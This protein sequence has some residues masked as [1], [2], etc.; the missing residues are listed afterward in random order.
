MVPFLG[1]LWIISIFG[2]G[3]WSLS[4]GRYHRRGYAVQNPDTPYVVLL[5]LA[6]LCGFGGGNFAS[7]MAT[8]PSSFQEGEGQR[9]R[10]QCGTRQSWVS[11]VQFV[12]PLVI[13]AGL[14]GALGGDPAW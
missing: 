4:P 14:F 5:I 7:S 2:R 8:S 12:V 1:R 10:A 9:P 6:L 3:L 11:V 13:T